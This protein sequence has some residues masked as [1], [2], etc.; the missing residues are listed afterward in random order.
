MKKIFLLFVAALLVSVSF[1]QLRD[2]IPAA[3]KKKQLMNLSN[4]PNDHFLVQF[5]YANWAGAPDSVNNRKGGFSKSFNV[6]FMF[7]FPFKSNPKLS[8]AFGPGISSDHIVFTK[9]LVGIKENT[10]SMRFSNLSD[11]NHF[12]KSKLA[13]VYLEAPIEFRYTKDP[14]NSGKSFKLALGVKIGTMINAHTRNTKYQDRNE[15]PIY[16]GGDYTM[17]EA[18]KKFFNKTRLVGSL[19]VGL[20]NISLFGQYQLTTLFKDGSGPQVRPYSIGVTLS[21]L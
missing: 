20:G 3:P 13:T 17:K 15:N 11:T 16:S 4:R 14:F 7:D 9:T 6:Y 21:G 1:A 2:S 10:N 18:S 5:G 19:R 12:R 8:M